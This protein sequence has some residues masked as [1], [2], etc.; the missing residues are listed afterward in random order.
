MDNMKTH[1]VRNVMKKDLKMSFK[2]IN[3]LALTAN[4]HR[5]LILRQQF[6]LAYLDI[7]FD[8]KVLLSVD[9]SW[10]AMADFRHRKWCQHNN[11]NSVAKL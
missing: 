4:S 6:A 5:N 8:K 3:P 2:K 7:D 9:E 11:N 1:L 10:L